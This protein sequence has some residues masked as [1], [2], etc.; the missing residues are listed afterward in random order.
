ML[1]LI[2]L[3][4]QE[5]SYPDANDETTNKSGITGIWKIVECQMGMMS[6]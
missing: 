1:C 2:G 5:H 4:L 3:S 6:A